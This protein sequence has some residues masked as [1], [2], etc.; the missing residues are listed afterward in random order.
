MNKNPTKVILFV[1]G[2]FP[3]PNQVA[4]QIVDD[5]YLVAVDGGLKHLTSLGL[6][7]DLIIGDLDSADKKA[8]GDWQSSGTEVRS[9]P[10]DK[11]ETDL[12]IAL[13]AALDLSPKAIWVV[14]ALGGRIDQTLGNIFLLTQ[15][16][17][18]EFDIRLIDGLREVFVIRSSATIQGIAGQRV[19]LIPLHGP[20]RGIQST[21]LAFPLQNDTLYPE[22]TRGISN[23]LTAQ[24]ATVSVQSGILL[25]IHE[26]TEPNQRSEQ[27][28]SD[29]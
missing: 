6:K 28:D 17:L 12:E 11:D 10:E 21:G 22:K 8:V 26:T 25:C 14:A 13:S 2:D 27:D 23:Q 19:S 4:C 5:D 9:Y 29:H 3:D 20:A 7:P 15:P 16:E 24:S 1:N 18:A